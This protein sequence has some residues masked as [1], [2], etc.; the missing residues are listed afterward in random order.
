MGLPTEFK[1]KKLNKGE[2]VSFQEGQLTGVRWMDKRPV[3]ALSTI[4]DASMTTVSRRSRAAEGGVERIR[5]P[6]MIVEYNTYMG[7]VD[8]AD[9]LVT[10][11]GFS[12]C[13]RKW[14]KRDFFHL[15]EVC[16][17]NAYIMYSSKN[18][19]KLTHLD[20]VITVSRQLIERFD[21]RQN[22]FPPDPA[23]DHPIRLTGRNHFPELTENKRDCCVCSSRGD[24]TGRKRSS[25]RCTTCKAYL[26]V[27]P[28]FMLYHTKNNY[29]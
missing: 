11:Y 17:V 29:K 1:K 22:I 10:Y 9:Q 3:S 26:C 6:T 18:H 19:K 23:I 16:M 27:D 28:C 2:T 5:K 25:Y 12:H 14:W 8:I 24:P 7:G 20:F 13:S 15:L 21:G 4:H